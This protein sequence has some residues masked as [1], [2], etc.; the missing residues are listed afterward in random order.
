[1]KKIL[2][3]SIFMVSGIII[4]GQ[5]YVYL[6]NLSGFE[7]NN[8]EK[9]KLEQTATALVSSLPSTFQ[10]SFKVFDFGIYPVN[11]YIDG[12]IEEI[13]L[14][15]KANADIRSDYYFLFG[16]IQNNLGEA[17]FWVKLKLPNDG[18]FQCFN[19]VYF[20]LLEN[21]VLNNLEN[22]FTRNESLPSAYSDVA[23]E[24]MNYL[25]SRIS[26]MIGCCD[27]R[28]RNPEDACN[29]CPKA[30]DILMKYRN[31][32]FD[33]T[34]ITIDLDEFGLPVRFKEENHPNILDFATIAYTEEGHGMYLFGSVAA[35]IDMNMDGSEDVLGV[36][37]DNESLC[38]DPALTAM[39]NSDFSATK[40]FENDFEV[41]GKILV[42][43]YHVWQ[44][45]N[46]SG[47]DKLLWKY[48]YAKNGKLLENDIPLN[49]NN[50]GVNKPTDFNYPLS[51]VKNCT[52]DLK[53]YEVKKDENGIYHGYELVNCQWQKRGIVERMVPSPYPLEPGN[54]Q[55]IFGESKMNPPYK[56]VRKKT[57]LTKAGPG[58][59]PR[60]IEDIYYFPCRTCFEYSKG[61]KRTTPTNELIKK[62][63]NAFEFGT[64]H[65]VQK[66]ILFNS[67]IYGK[68]QPVIWKAGNKLSS[69]LEF[70][71]LGVILK[72]F[73]ITQEITKW[74]KDN[75][76]LEG[77]IESEIAG[78][79]LEDRPYFRHMLWAEQMFGGT[80]AA[81]I[82]L[83]KFKEIDPDLN[84]SKKFEVEFL[85]T[86]FDN[87]GLGNDERWNTPGIV[88]Q[89]VL[90]H[91]RNNYCC[92]NQAFYPINHHQVEFHDKFFIDICN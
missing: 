16:R 48:L 56:E 17:S 49:P 83:V 67:F 10:T 19:Q 35:E 89:W 5:N 46:G 26:D 4:Y 61:S 62:F 72:K 9:Q 15:L 82:K 50:L 29:V 74:V 38:V 21:S 86:V 57:V 24:G 20:D 68:G 87:F 36:I 14:D 76:T 6:S 79:I 59:V 32:G 63:Y 92:G 41:E 64:S 1:M 69:D 44:N 53:L 75:G 51:D 30:E 54:S 13:S 7:Y 77:F 27:V 2:I 34:D 65:Q 18:N 60:E 52:N 55:Y 40:L 39:R 91:Y 23:I 70:F 11:G 78:N 45:P 88:E 58:F 8:S 80:Q 31:L 90:Q 84:C 71:N 85:Y 25:K 33:E 12:R 22:N 3:F 28:L 66:D 73:E 43:V 42:I 47:K 81:S 37:L